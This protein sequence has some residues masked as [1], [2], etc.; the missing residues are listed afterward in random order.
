MRRRCKPGTRQ[1]P[2]RRRIRGERGAVAAQHE[3]IG[4]DERGLEVDRGAADVEVA[5]EGVGVGE[6]GRD[7]EAGRLLVDEGEVGVADA[8]GGQVGHLG[9]LGG[10]ADAAGGE[11][12]VLLEPGEGGRDRGAQV[13]GRV[14]H[15]DNVAVIEGEGGADGGG[16]GGDWGWRLVRGLGR[17]LGGD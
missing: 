8:R 15:D 1:E 6:V 14:D 4:R 17:E 2:R 13:R 16:F 3:P 12:D 5:P 10:G 9:R 7:D 11:G